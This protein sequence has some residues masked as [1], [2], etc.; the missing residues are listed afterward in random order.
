MR[1]AVVLP[2]DVRRRRDADR[3][4]DARHGPGRGPVRAVR[5]APRAR[6]HRRGVPDA[7]RRALVHQLGLA[8]ARARR[9]LSLRAWALGPLRGLAWPSLVAGV[10]AAVAFRLRA[11]AFVG[12][13]ALPGAPGRFGR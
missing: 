13:A 5:L 7:D 6:V 10:V 11:A 3:G 2:A 12:Q 1:L 4:P 8:D 9:G